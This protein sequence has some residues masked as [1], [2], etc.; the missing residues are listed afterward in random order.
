MTPRRVEVLVRLPRPAT[1]AQRR[2]A[3]TVGFIDWTSSEYRAAI[4]LRALADL[5]T[6]CGERGSEMTSA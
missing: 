2:W 6:R 5:E 4:A 1:E 3:L